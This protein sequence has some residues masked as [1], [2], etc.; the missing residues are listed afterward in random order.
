MH[1]YVISWFRR[2]V[3]TFLWELPYS[4]SPV[5]CIY[6][7][8]PLIARIALQFLCRLPSALL[9][10]K[11][12]C[13]RSYPQLF[14]YISHAECPTFWRF[15]HPLTAGCPIYLRRASFGVPSLLVH[16]LLRAII[17]CWF[18]LSL[19]D[20]RDGSLWKRHR[21]KEAKL[22][23]KSTTAAHQRRMRCCNPCGATVQSWLRSVC[24]CL[25]KLRKLMPG[26]IPRPHG[27][28]PAAPWNITGRHIKANFRASQPC[29]WS[30][31]ESRAV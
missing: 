15:P 28:D 22:V 5:P 6:R 13:R 7:N 19:S 31:F 3:F 23:T 29:S 12:L 16:P 18:S 11:I 17:L 14:L 21:R 20:S 2:V 30:V 4:S 1:S 9:V 10:A 26:M 24:S 27:W 25:A 8:C